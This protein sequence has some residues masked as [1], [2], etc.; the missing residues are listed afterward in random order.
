MRTAGLTVTLA[1]LDA[2]DRPPV[3]APAEVALYRVCQEALTNALRH[4]GPVA[5]RIS[6]TRSDKDAILTIESDA[7]DGARPAAV[8]SGGM[9]IPGMRERMRAVG[10]TLD[11]GPTAT[12]GFAVIACVPLDPA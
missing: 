11:A 1:G 10:G 2:P 12:G 7:A 4:A 6:L 5:V 3:S 8:A 9:G